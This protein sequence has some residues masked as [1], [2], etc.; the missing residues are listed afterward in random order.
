VFPQKKAIIMKR[1][2]ENRVN[3]GPSN[4]R[5]GDSLSWCSAVERRSN[6]VSHLVQSQRSLNGLSVR[7]HKF[8]IDIRTSL[9]TVFSRQSKADEYVPGGAHCKR[10]FIV[11]NLQKNSNRTRIME[12]CSRTRGQLRPVPCQFK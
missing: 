1:P 5:R 10:V 3:G 12:L 2:E 7:K 4:G 11:S 9:R 8:L 6:S